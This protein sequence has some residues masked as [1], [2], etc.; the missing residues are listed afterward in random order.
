MVD[1]GV[2]DFKVYV[3]SDCGGDY[4]PKTGGD[5][6]R[7]TAH[8]AFGTIHRFHGS[9]H[10]PW[11]YDNHTE[12]VIRSY[13][14][15]RYSMAPS[16]VAAGQAAAET[17]FPFVTRCDLF[18]P[19]HAA[20]GAFDNT[21]YIFI[22]DT[23]IA[24][25]YDST[26]NETTRSV[27]VPPGDWAD[28]WTGEVVSGPKTIQVTKGY[29]QQPMWHKKDGGLMVV[30]NTPGLRSVLFSSLFFDPVLCF[31]SEMGC[32]QL[33]PHNSTLC[34]LNFGK[35]TTRSDCDV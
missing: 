25:I 24:P 13:L 8:C 26:A 35:L 4:R 2:H 11:G 6:L 32:L 29:E 9:D 12:D 15:T 33:T 1:A 21:Q 5:L 18:W 23:L 30:T 10:R 27:W 3:H 20:E 19:E 31:D 7:W 28:A 17:G 34:L 16:L 14:T 22:N